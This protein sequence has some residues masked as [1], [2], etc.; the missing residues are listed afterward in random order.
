MKIEEVAPKKES[1]LSLLAHEEEEEGEEEIDEREIDEENEAYLDDA[2]PEGDDTGLNSANAMQEAAKIA[3]TLQPTGFT[4]KDTNVKTPVPFLLK[5][6]LREYQHVAVDWLVTLH[7]KKLNGILADEMGLGTRR[8]LCVPACVADVAAPGKTIMTISTLAHLACEK[9]I[10]GPHLVIVPTSVRPV[11]SLVPC[12]ESLTSALQVMLNWEMEFKKWCP[13]FKILSYWG[14][15]K[16]RAK[17]RIGWSKPNAF[18]VCITSY[19][20]VLQAR[21]PLRS[22]FSR[23]AHPVCRTRVL[24]VAC[25]GTS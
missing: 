1:A 9:G 2:E 22:P 21:L 14:S 3:Q 10:W 5:H 24:F 15:Q 25:R 11:R 17:K 4:L 18:H 8:P 19:S 13:A 6:P 16:E 23:P 12:S 7:D 20:T